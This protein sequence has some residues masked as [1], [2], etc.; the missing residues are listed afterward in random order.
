MLKNDNANGKTDDNTIDNA[1]DNADGK[2]KLPQK[3]T[4]GDKRQLKQKT[5]MTTLI[6]SIN[7]LTAAYGK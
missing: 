1:N 2:H 7:H 3:S 4:N 5:Q 6:A